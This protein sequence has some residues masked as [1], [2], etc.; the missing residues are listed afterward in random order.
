MRSWGAPAQVYIAAVGVLLRC[1]AGRSCWAASMA[2]CVAVA[3]PTG[4]VGCSSPHRRPLELQSDCAD[5][6]ARRAELSLF[7]GRPERAIELYQQAGSQSPLTLGGRLR[8]AQAYNAAG[9][10]AAAEAQLLRCVESSPGEAAAHR[11]LATFYA[12]RGRDADA[13]QAFERVVACQPDSVSARMSV[14]HLRLATGDAP[15]GVGRLR[16]VL[17]R[18]PAQLAASVML[19]TALRDQGRTESALA[20]LKEATAA[21]PSSAEACHELACAYEDAGMPV[22]AEAAYRRATDRD[23]SFMAPRN[24]LAY[25]YARQ[26][27]KLSEAEELARAVVRAHPGDAQMLDTLGLIQLKRGETEESVVTLDR[28]ARSGPQESNILYHLG[29]ACAE[30]GAKQRAIEALSESLR[31]GKPFDEE[32]DCRALLAGLGVGP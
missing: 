24:N 8:L 6:L 3:L 1:G 7:Q 19:A 13:L 2:L 11:A 16:E 27:R 32:Q 29:W 17:R 25:L 22:E 12:S 18:Q 9:D 15:G 30:F 26:G 21:A 20:C 28:A 10:L 14:A 4:M 23:P 5:T 31:I